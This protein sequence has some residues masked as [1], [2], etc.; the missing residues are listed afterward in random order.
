M[1]YRPCRQA[2]K[3]ICGRLALKELSSAQARISIRVSV[4]CV[5]K[6]EPAYDRLTI[7]WKPRKSA[8]KPDSGRH[9]Q[10]DQWRSLWIPIVVPPSM[11]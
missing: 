2:D 8:R 5:A 11:E 3:A 9:Q 4:S 7:N 1:S 6:T 10:E